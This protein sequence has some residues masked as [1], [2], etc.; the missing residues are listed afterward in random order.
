[1]SDNYYKILGVDQNSTKEDIKKAYRKLQMK[2]HPDKNSGLP[3]ADNLTRQI[4]EAYETLGDDQKR[5]EYD[6]MQS[7]PNP[8]TRMNS[9]HGAMGPNDLDDIISMMFGGVGASNLFNMSSMDQMEQM[10]SGPKIRVFHHSGSGPMGFQQAIQKPAPIIQTLTI[11]M[12]QVLNG[13]NVP[14]EIERWI[15]ENGNKVFEHE[16]IY[17]TIPKG[18]DDGEIIILREKGNILNE[19]IKGDL[20]VFIKINNETIFKRFGLDLILE[21]RISLK[22]ALCGFSF[23]IKYVN[24]KSYTL[25]NTRGNI[26]PPEYKKIYPNMGLEREGFKGNMIIHFHLDFPELLTEDQIVKLNEIL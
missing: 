14:M 3:N 5:K 9:F 17:V 15:I 13:G 10:N 8:F 4:N 26:I 19:T 11:S 18:V 24:G 7:N 16:T 1:M 21:K 12:E 23:E 6:F 2:Y 22:D 25:N 20:K